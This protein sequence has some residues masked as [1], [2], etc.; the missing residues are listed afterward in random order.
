MGGKFRDID[1]VHCHDDKFLNEV[2]KL[3]YHICWEECGRYSPRL[4]HDK[5][6]LLGGVRQVFAAS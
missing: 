1:V 6:I 3:R 4:D 5:K 2:M